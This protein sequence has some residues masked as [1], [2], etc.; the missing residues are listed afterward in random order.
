MAKYHTYLSLSLTTP[1]A[2]L[3]AKTLSELKRMSPDLT[4]M[5]ASWVRDEQNYYFTKLGEI[6]LMNNY[7]MWI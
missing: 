4:Q 7:E 5:A 2:S 6:M 3:F 1:V